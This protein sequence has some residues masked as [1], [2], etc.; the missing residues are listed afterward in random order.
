[1]ILVGGGSI[2]PQLLEKCI[3]NNI[4]IFITYGQTE[5]CSGITGFWIKNNPNKLKSV[6]KPF[7]NVN[8]STT[9]QNKEYSNINI[10]GDNI[11]N[12]YWNQ[13]RLNSKFITDDLGKFDTDGFLY[14][15]PHTKNKIVT[16]GA[17]VNPVEVELVIQKYPNIIDCCVI[18]FKNK[19]W[20]EEIIAFIHT[21]KNIIYDDLIKY[22]KNYLLEFKIP[23]RFIKC[24]EIPKNE[25]GKI[26]RL[27][28]EKI[29][30]DHGHI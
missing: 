29:L 10:Q 25:L 11:S 23:K 24:N 15:K 28:A 5:T 7:D 18:G 8:I 27:K 13:I 26:N 30:K 1:M 21:N 12:G 16:G 3:I 17:N 4:N 20:G 6:G 22:C 9:A 2:D 14:L 19:K